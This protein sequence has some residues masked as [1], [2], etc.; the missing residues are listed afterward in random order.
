MPSE[1]QVAVQRQ[2]WRSGKHV[3]NAKP[4]VRVFVRKGR[5]R[6]SYQQK[7]AKDVYS[8]V[9]GLMGPDYVWSARWEPMTEYREVQGVVNIRCDTD[10]DKNGVDT[11]TLTI[12][13]TQM[14]QE[15]GL[16]GVF[17]KIRRGF[18]AP[19]RGHRGGYAPAAGERNEWF[20]VW[21]D[22][23]TQIM[24]LGGYG[25]A[26]FPL[27][28]GL[29]DNTEVTSKPD[30]IVATFRNMGKILTDQHTFGDAKNLW[31]R[32]PITFH[33]RLQ[34]HD[35][36]NVASGATS[37]SRRPG[38]PP[39]MATDGD[40]ETAWRSDAYST[41][42]SL[43]WIEVTLPAGSYV[44]FNILPLWAGMRMY[45]SV[46][47]TN[48]NVPGKGNAR[49]GNG[50]PLPLTDGWLDTGKGTV[51][52]TSVPFT[53][54]VPSL[55][56]R[57][58]A[59]NL[60]SG[61]GLVVGDGTK[62][63]IWFQRLHQVK[64][65]EYRAGVRDIRIWKRTMPKEVRDQGWILVDDAADMVRT[66]LQW[67]GF[68]DWEVEDTGVRLSD[69]IVFDR[70]TFLIDIIRWVCERT[71]YVFFIRPPDDFDPNDLSVGNELNR[72]MGVAVFRQSTAIRQNLPAGEGRE[73]I[74]DKDILTGFKARFDNTVQADSIRVRGKNVSQVR[75][76]RN[77]E[78]I[79]PLGA[80][81]LNRFQYSYR[82]PWAQGD[83]TSG[84]RVHTLH[85]DEMIESVYEAKVGSLLIGIAQAL[86]SVTAELEAPM[87]P[88]THLDSQVVVLDEGT[89][90]STRLWVA[91]RSWE[92]QGG[93]NVRFKMALGGA[94]LDAD[95]TMKLREELEILLNDRGYMPSPIAR[96]PWTEVREF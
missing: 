41:Q 58:T 49:Y 45:V 39:S 60:D 70:Q 48:R 52:G 57:R 59:H 51:P 68:E 65:G 53:L 4:V 87:W 46:R 24:V 42:N 80:D 17:H 18:M 13:N 83:R 71:G 78:W 29:L 8:H 77:P 81:R 82:P 79:H 1:G 74:T 54:H 84:V 47:P 89:G 50:D 67:A 9:P 12:D 25:D 40:D 91:S 20:G 2:R 66:V 21:R 62:V 63:R 7:P 6:R 90:T 56:G 26:V 36:D 61:R 88:L 95:D 96:S 16:A 75:A 76:R 64:P 10:F 11:L 5:L 30:Q 3:G 15:T 37:K 32:D 31:I 34:A 19:M 27:F 86:G 92:Y 55:A 69:K 23:S 14:G 43:D 28:T 73:V 85:Y 38:F 94:C 93:K 44:N 35:K 33:D 22:R 72:S